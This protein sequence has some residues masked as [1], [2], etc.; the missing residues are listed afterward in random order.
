MVEVCWG[1]FGGVSGL[2]VDAVAL[3][4]SDLVALDGVAL[5]VVLTCDFA[6][7]CFGGGFTVCG[8][9]LG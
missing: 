7:L 6:D 8:E 9:G 5:F 3:G 1:C 2:D 4:C